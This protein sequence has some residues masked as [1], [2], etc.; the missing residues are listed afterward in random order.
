MRKPSLTLRLTLLFGA[1]FATV[2]FGLGHF[3]HGAVARHF[4]EGDLQELYAKLDF[5]RYL[6]ANATTPAALAGVPQQLDAALVGHDDLAVAL[7]RADGGVVYVSPGA[8]FPAEQLG[9]VAPASDPARPPARVW[10]H[11]GRYYRGIVADI[12]G[13]GAERPAMRVVV[14]RDIA[15]HRTF[16]AHFVRSLWLAIVL[17]LVLS[18]LLGWLAARVGLAPLRRMA[19]VAR[20]VSAQSLHDRI[21]LAE[22]PAELHG[23]AGEFNDMMERLQAGF[24]RLTEFS[25]DIAHELRTPI[26]NLM[27][28]TQVAL[29]RSRSADEYRD[30]LHSNL[31]EFDRLARMIGDMLFLAKADNG[32][33]PRPAQNVSLALE[34]RDLAE[35]YEAY[36]EEKGVRLTVTGGAHVIGERLMLRRALSN[37]VS[38]AVR[39]TAAGGTVAIEIAAEDGGA[40]VAVRNPGPPIP[41]EQLPRIFERFHR[42]DAARARQGEGAGLGLAITRSIILAHGGRIG[43]ESAAGTT[44]FTFWLPSAVAPDGTDAA[45]SSADKEST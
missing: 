32:L 28:Q 6:L 35:F 34:A 16:M 2:L 23:L 13:S 17:A 15:L 22:L 5:T 21:P 43:V 42:V 30:I 38:N 29:S 11:D 26:S 24:A 41:P 1:V 45:Q 33:L 4:E 12:A 10:V 44:V 36:A 20:G 7:V 9:E 8:P 3:I 19:A 14:A 40:R 18:G 27:T 39:H 31:E 37:L 25:S